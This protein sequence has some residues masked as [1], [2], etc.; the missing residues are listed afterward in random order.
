MNVAVIFAGGTGRRMKTSEKP[1]QFLLVHGK[2]IIVH[3][4]EIFETHPDIDG[5]VIACLEEYIGHMNDLVYR[6]RLDKVKAIVPGGRT[7]Q[8][9]IYNGVKKAAELYEDEATV[10]LIHDGV[11]PFIDHDLISRNIE[12]VKKNGSCITCAPAS[13]TFVILNEDAEVDHIMNRNLSQSAKAP[14]SFYLHD[15]LKKE[16]QALKDGY[17][18][19]IDSVT[20]MCHYGLKPAITECG[21]DNIKI[22]TPNDFYIFRALYDARENSQ[23]D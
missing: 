7:G 3:T 9:S 12:C 16:E 23:L 15:I 22:T 18:D 21:S 14:Q 10:A 1:K 11:R 2:P 20:L 6:Y 17:D 8:L 19:M 4:V 13:E 5:I